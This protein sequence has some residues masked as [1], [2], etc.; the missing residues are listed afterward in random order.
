MLLTIQFD[1]SVTFQNSYSK[2]LL[3]VN[4][5][6]WTFLDLIRDEPSQ[7]RLKRALNMAKSGER[8]ESFNCEL[9]LDKGGKITLLTA[10]AAKHG[11]SDEPL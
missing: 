11:L 1:G 10:C 5:Q 8:I 9:I 6:K 2:E 3:S 4:A 7:Q